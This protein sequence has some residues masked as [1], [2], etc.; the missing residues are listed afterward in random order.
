MNEIFK[1]KGMDKIVLCE[2]YYLEPDNFKG[3][4][5]VFH[6]QRTKTK[7]DDTTESYLF[8]DRFYYPKLSQTLDKYLI[9]KQTKAKDIEDLKDIVL[10]VEQTIKNL[11]Q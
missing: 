9:L 6:E 1:A 2:N 3:L 7:K 8:E 4:V 11:S 5:L 10:R